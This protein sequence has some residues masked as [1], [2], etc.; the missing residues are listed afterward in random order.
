MLH[1]GVNP[2]QPVQAPA[3]PATAQREPSNAHGFA[4]KVLITIGLVALAFFTWQ[5]LDVIVLLFGAVLFAVALRAMSM[6]LKP[7]LGNSERVAIAVVVVTLAGALGVGVWLTGDVVIQQLQALRDVLPSALE[8][9]EAWLNSN[10]VGLFL[11]D[12]WEN[13]RKNGLEA[14][15]GRVAGFATSALTA[16]TSVV[17]LLIIAIYLAGD[18]GIYRR[19]FLHLVPVRLRARVDDAL[20]ATGDGL[21]SW[22]LGQLVS[23]VAIGTMTMTGLLLLGAPMAVLLGLIAGLLAFV[24]FF[25]A[26]ASG[27]LAVLL[28]FTQG[29]Q[30]ALYVAL[31]ML[32]IQQ[33]EEYV[34]LPVVQRW[35]VAL[36][37]VLGLVAVLLFGIL[38]GIPGVLFATP[39][40]VMV[41]ILVNHLY[42]QTVVEPEP[43]P[44]ELGDGPATPDLERMES[45][46]SDPEEKP[47]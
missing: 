42:V 10:A 43:S 39:M 12:L 16:I 45:T 9:A 4:A 31:L 26:I 23:M 1:R 3:L 21:R 5:L 40:M 27:V 7:Y 15:W 8:A 28:A 18:P 35:A 38:F 19:G 37:P 24:P 14:D 47:A 13:A 25:G 30:Q 29:A 33:V 6:P 17:L 11:V 20:L 32:G 44:S 41:M 36:Q 46:R 2:P 22:L 34:L